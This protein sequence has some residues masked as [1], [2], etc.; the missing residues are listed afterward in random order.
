MHTQSK[1]W[2]LVAVGMSLAVRNATVVC[3]G[4]VV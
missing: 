1:D 2:T 4:L 3:R